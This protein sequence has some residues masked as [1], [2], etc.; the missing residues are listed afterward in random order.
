MVDADIGALAIAL[1]RA[2]EVFQ[3]K[4]SDGIVSE[5]YTALQKFPIRQVVWAVEQ[6]I[7]DCLFFPK[8]REIRDAMF[9]ERHEGES[10]YRRK[11]LALPEPHD[12]EVYARFKRDAAALVARISTSLPHMP[13]V[14]A[15]HQPI[16]YQKI[17]EQERWAMDESHWRARWDMAT[18]PKHPDLRC[19]LD[20]IPDKYR[21]QFAMEDR[22][23]GAT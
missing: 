16:A 21:V 6:C 18:N 23:R 5:Y 11:P 22:E 3:F 17:R 12:P 14:R 2:A 20:T 19:L 8:P 1:G 10:E 13:S 15:D 9:A 7:T 4:L